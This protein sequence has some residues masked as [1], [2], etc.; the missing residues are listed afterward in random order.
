[1]DF[2]ALPCEASG[3][4]LCASSGRNTLQSTARKYK[5]VT[6]SQRETQHIRMP[7]ASSPVAPFN[8]IQA[9]AL[10][11]NPNSAWTRI[12][13]RRSDY[14]VIVIAQ[15]MSRDHRHLGWLQGAG[16][17][18]TAAIAGTLTLITV[19]AIGG[20]GLAILDAVGMGPWPSAVRALTGASPAVS[21]LLSHTTLYLLAGIT[22]LALARVADRLPILLI[23]LVLVI[24][25]MEF[26]YLVVM[27]G[28]QA[29]GH[30]DG[31]TWQSV[32]LAHVVANLFLLIG[33]L[34]V[35]PSLRLAFRRAYQE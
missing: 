2:C 25:V 7:G 20:R 6:R 3:Q 11:Y 27:T 32:L 18:L 23:G 8:W 19:S 33:I 28:W 29:A 4:L 17:G 9:R 5:T 31:P 34:W 21:Y 14:E 16:V 24:L 15:P 35:H 13:A 26:A 22:A 10:A 12:D 1:L 30:F